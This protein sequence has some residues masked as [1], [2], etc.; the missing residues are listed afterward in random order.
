M[1]AQNIPHKKPKAGSIPKPI[2]VKIEEKQTPFINHDNGHSAFIFSDPTST[3]V[4]RFERFRSTKTKELADYSSSLLFE[5]IIGETKPGEL[6]GLFGFNFPFYRESVSE[7]S[8]IFSGSGFT[9]PQRR[10][11]KNKPELVDYVT[12]E[13][14]LCLRDKFF[15][16]NRNRKLKT[17]DKRI[18][19]SILLY[20][21]DLHPFGNI[22]LR[23]HSFSGDSDYM[24]KSIVKNRRF[25][26]DGA[27]QKML[28]SFKTKK[29]LLIVRNE[30]GLGI[31]S[32]KNMLIRHNILRHWN[33]HRLS[34][35]QKL[36]IK[37][38]LKKRLSGKF[39]HQEIDQTMDKML[40]RNY[41]K[42]KELTH[43]QKQAVVENLSEI[44]KALTREFSDFVFNI[45]KTEL[46]SGNRMLFAFEKE[47][48]S[49]A[50][51]HL[52]KIEKEYAKPR[53]GWVIEK[54]LDGFV[55]LK[56]TKNPSHSPAK[57]LI[58]SINDDGRPIPQCPLISFQVFKELE[59]LGFDR[60][61]MAFHDEE[62][63]VVEGAAYLAKNLFGIKMPILIVHFDRQHANPLYMAEDGMGIYTQ[64]GS[65]PSLNLED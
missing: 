5:E 21:S 62:A 52:K 17:Q 30:I 10:L 49:K 55:Y 40:S 37:K 39:S 45:N 34:K 25:Y 33:K 58:A 16:Y 12:L 11:V 8:V 61:V 51:K 43:A 1:N 60:M 50:A 9:I 20:P 57:I 48:F 53:D 23:Q 2:S 18:N 28:E 26:G 38:I 31:G 64:I 15:E 22:D 42:E 63:K 27:A 19:G 24:R 6:V 13:T 47:Y 44:E 65:G 29:D 54:S 32:D 36:L 14:M 35:E 59:S 46:I 7:N 56:E 41:M 4:K 3:K